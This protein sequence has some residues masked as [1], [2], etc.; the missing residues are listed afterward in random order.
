MFALS[1]S[2]R[3][4]PAAA[5][6]S[7]HRVKWLFKWFLRL[8]LVA[9][10]LV[11]LLCFTKDPVLRVV[12]EKRIHSA[13]GM[14]A[15]IGKFSSGRNGAATYVTLENLKLYNTAEFGGGLFLDIPELHLECDPV[16]FAQSKLHFTVARL[17]L[18][19]LDIVKNAAGKTNVLALQ[20]LLTRGGATT[21]GTPASLGGFE[22]QGIDALILSLGRAKFVDLKDAKHNRE[23]PVNLDKQAFTNVKAE[24]DI[25]GIAFMLWLRTGGKF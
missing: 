10:V 13:T 21:N 16:A 18:A 24:A 25:Y 3:D 6:H 23:I 11:A 20:K 1:A 22:F 9:V 2:I 14:E 17:N 15:Q 12:V 8:L 4:C 5:C 19:E 7:K